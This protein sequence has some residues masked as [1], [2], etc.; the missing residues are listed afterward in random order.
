ML[1][2]VLMKPRLSNRWI[3]EALANR[4]V[5]VLFFPSKSEHTWVVPYLMKKRNGW[6]DYSPVECFATANKGNQILV[7]VADRRSFYNRYIQAGSL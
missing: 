6:S 2:T 3:W 5:F 7:I 4:S 1:G